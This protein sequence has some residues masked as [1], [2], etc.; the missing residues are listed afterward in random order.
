MSPQGSATNVARG[1]V[2]KGRDPASPNPSGFPTKGVTTPQKAQPAPCAYGWT[3]HVTLLGFVRRPRRLFSTPC[4]P[5]AIGPVER[6][7]L[8][9]GTPAR[10]IQGIYWLF[11]YMLI[12]I[13]TYI[14]N[15]QHR[16]NYIPFYTILSFYT[17]H[18]WVYTIN[19]TWVWTYVIRKPIM[20]GGTPRSSSHGMSFLWI[21][22]EKLIGADVHFEPFSYACIYFIHL[23][24][25][26]L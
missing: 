7:G 22:H 13:Y 5:W 12:H 16:D 17:I 3:S 9:V 26:K 25:Y 11:T 6:R 8:H 14:Y 18:I 4:G 23:H 20:A 15:H 1:G 2:Y 10:H 24:M 21:K 19:N